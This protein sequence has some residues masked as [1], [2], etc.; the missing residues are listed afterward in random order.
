VEFIGLTPEDNSL[1]ERIRTYL[2]E[3]GMTWPNG[4]GA[5]KTLDEW[6]VS[7]I[8][9]VFVVG[10]DGRLVWTHVGQSDQL[11]AAIERALSQ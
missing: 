6:K 4:Y 2:D 7:A 1:L 8:P 5:E 10:R 11:G 9:V 3:V